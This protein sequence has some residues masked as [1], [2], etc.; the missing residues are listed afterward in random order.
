VTPSW[1]ARM[2]LPTAEAVGSPS[3]ADKDDKRVAAEFV[4]LTV[5]IVVPTIDA[6]AADAGAVDLA[7]IL[8]A[9]GHHPIV[10]SS[11]GRLEGAVRAAGVETIRL[12]TAS[13]NPWV[14][15]RNAVALM[16][17]VRE[18]RCDVIH[19][20][21]R[22]PGWSSYIA[23]R[24]T[25]A[26]FL[27]S[28]YKGFREQNALKRLYNGVMA[29][30][31]RVIAVSDQIADFIIEHHGTPSERIVVVPSIVDFDHFDPAGVSPDR[32]DRARH[33]WGVKSDTKVIV[34]T[35]RMVRRKGHDV[36]VRAVQRLKDAGLKDFVCVF[37]GEEQRK[38]RYG[39]EL[40]DLVLATNTADVIRRAGPGEDRAASYAA[41]TLVVSAAIQAEGLQRAI[42]EALAM[43]RPVVTS[44][45]AAGPDVVQAPPLV[46]EER[47]T[48]LRVP[49]G[50][51]AALAAALIR[52]LSLPEAA[53]RAMGMRG[54]E[55]VISHFDP[56]TV[57]QQ[58]LA[59][60]AEVAR[61]RK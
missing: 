13:R 17:I 6:G 30:G 56:A 36:V 54:R 7:R 44:D 38:T 60:Y 53:R 14:I 51:D 1:T 4:A 16:R 43:A 58:T 42:L 57:V 2:P 37:A 45:L 22:A 26:R 21:G 46:A 33:T 61:S 8:R 31:D 59:I 50:D 41:A 5:L 40:W 48:G 35:G 34:V 15:M 18:R 29:R 28:W 49:A 55:W 3:A 9:A 32:V 47:M 25:G 20:H 27:T 39:G 24:L 52:L 19:A 23:A 11:G 10:V 12:D